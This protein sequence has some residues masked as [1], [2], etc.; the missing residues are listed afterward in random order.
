MAR[1]GQSPK[2][3]RRG[4]Q[5]CSFTM[6]T[7]I[8]SLIAKDHE[9]LPNMKLAVCI[10]HI[11]PIQSYRLLSSWPICLRALRCIT[12]LLNRDVQRDRGGKNMWQN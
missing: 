2:Q 12:P 11:L 6:S 5:S 1:R 4:V 9:H 8:K 3:K 7:L 10:S